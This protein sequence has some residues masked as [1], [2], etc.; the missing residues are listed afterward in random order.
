[1]TFQVVGLACACAGQIIEKRVKA[2]KG[3][4]TFSLNPITNQ[5]KIT[6]HPSALSV[7]DIQAAV[8]KAGATAIPTA[9]RPA[10]N[11]AAVLEGPAG[12]AG[13]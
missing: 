12:L 10:T 1:M 7:Q 9:T 5:M 13:V 6:Y 4:T 8:K 3:I 2:L 11:E